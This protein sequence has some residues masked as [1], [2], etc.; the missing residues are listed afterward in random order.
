MA[1]FAEMTQQQQAQQQPQQSL[2]LQWGGGGEGGVFI[3]KPE[4]RAKW[5]ALIDAL[6]GQEGA[7]VDLRVVW[8]KLLTDR[9]VFRWNPETKQREQKYPNARGTKGCGLLFE[10]REEGLEGLT[11][12][13]DC[14][15]SLFATTPL[16]KVVAAVARKKFGEKENVNPFQYVGGELILKVA[17]GGEVKVKEDGS[18]VNSGGRYWKI[19]AYSQVPVKVAFGQQA[20]APVAQPQ[21]QAPVAGNPAPADDLDD[22]D[23]IV[24][25]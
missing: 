2:S 9:K 22:A 13:Q 6:G 5:K 17:L 1:T 19:K 7:E 25:F 24:P 4:I 23:D 21:E 8:K 11:F 18:H 10:V 15:Q 14:A 3:E 20:P 16:A 12:Y